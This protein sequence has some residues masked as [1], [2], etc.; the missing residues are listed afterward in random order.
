[1]ISEKAISS[2]DHLF[3]EAAR[4]SL[5]LNPSDTCE[6]ASVPDDGA[7]NEGVPSTVL[8]ITCSSFVFRLFT[9]LR[10][11]DDAETRAYFTHGSG[12]EANW[13]DALF[14]AANLCSGAVNRSLSQYFPHIGMSTPYTLSS[15]CLSFLEDLQPQHVLHYAIRIR[16]SVRLRA[17]VCVCSYAPIDFS[18]DRMQ[19]TDTTSSGALELF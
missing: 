3:T 2:I 12:T 11:V 5:V 16:E 1:M 15:G 19:P 18:V 8:I 9:L 6:I 13:A 4:S 17:T 14:E 10:L 7:L